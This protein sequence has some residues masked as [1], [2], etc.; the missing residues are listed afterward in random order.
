[1][2]SEQL[3]P[4]YTSLVKFLHCTCQ[5]RQRGQGKNQKTPS[6]MVLRLEK[7]SFLR[8]TKDSGLFCFMLL[9][10]LRLLFI[11]HNRYWNVNV[12]NNAHTLLLSSFQISIKLF[13]KL[14]DRY[15]TCCT[16]FYSI[17]SICL[18]RYID[19]FCNCCSIFIIITLPFVF[20]L[21]NSNCTLSCASRCSV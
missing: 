18:C 1:M 16:N 11:F 8:C 17:I 20:F 21:C 12:S 19:L 5:V 13:V 9:Y 14:F 4:A 10:C 2:D 7:S 6:P 3:Y 15:L